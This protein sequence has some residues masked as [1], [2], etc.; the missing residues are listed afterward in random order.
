MSDKKHKCSF[1]NCQKSYTKPSYLKIHLN[2]HTNN[3]P[4]KCDQ[5]SKSYTKNSHLTVHKKSHSNE[6]LICSKCT[7]KFITKDKLKRHVNSCNILY[8]CKFCL[9]KYKRFKMLENHLILHS[10]GSK[11]YECDKCKSVYKS[12]RAFDKHLLKHF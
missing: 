3:R 12:K 1:P 6:F 7:K 11:I 4:F 9:K 8:E 10:K 2:S 5:C